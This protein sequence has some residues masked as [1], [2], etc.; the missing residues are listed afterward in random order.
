MDRRRVT[1]EGDS[2]IP[3]VS[4]I[5]ADV[6]ERPQLLRV[7]VRVEVAT[8]DVGIA[9]AAIDL[10]ADDRVEVRTAA[11]G[12]PHM[13]AGGADAGTGGGIGDT[14]GEA[15]CVVLGAL[16]RAPAEVRTALLSRRDDG[17]LFDTGLTD[18]A[19]IH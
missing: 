18:I 3:I 4:G 2:V 15:G 7:V 17:D 8:R 9:P 12:R 10:S 13:F 19:D 6:Q 14:L 1:G 16:E 11:A 5:P